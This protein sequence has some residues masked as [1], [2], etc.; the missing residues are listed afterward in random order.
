[1]RYAH[2]SGKNA[3]FRTERY[4][5]LFQKLCLITK[6]EEDGYYYYKAHIEV[7]YCYNNSI[8]L[9]CHI[10]MH[11]YYFNNHTTCICTVAVTVTTL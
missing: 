11:T 2:Y 4:V 10:N 1:M 9:W 8:I 3:R 7:H 6:R 5:F